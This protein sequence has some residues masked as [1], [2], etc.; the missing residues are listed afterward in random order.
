MQ[1][2]LIE[3]GE[4]RGPFE[5]YEVRE[6]IR[7]GEI[8]ATRKIW[9]EGAEGWISAREVGVLK[10]EFEKLRVEP[11]PIPK[12]LLVKPPF[13][14]WRRFGAR[15]FD[16]SLYLLLILAVFRAGGVSPSPDPNEGPSLGDVFLIMIP[17]VIMEGTLIGAFGHTPGKW[18]MS[19]KVSRPEGGKLSTGASIMRALRAWVLGMGMSHPI[20]LPLGHLIALWMV[21]K[22]GAPLWDL[23]MGFRVEGARLIP[24]RVVAFVVLFAVIFV[25]S[26]AL[27]WSQFE[28]IFREAYE[29]AQ[30]QQKMK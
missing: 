27:R 8:S 12:E 29:E 11:P 1:F 18:L 24:G 13:L 19:L 2:W 15:W 6:M 7:K 9:H 5:D 4:K 23:P 3:D 28:P 30:R 14:Y 16:Y 10:S 21:R 17:F 26:V 25:G 20:L 22:K